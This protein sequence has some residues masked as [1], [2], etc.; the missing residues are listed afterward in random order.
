MTHLLRT[1]P[2]FFLITVAV[3]LQTVLLFYYNFNG[4][5]GQD[6]YEYLRI[7]R[8]ISLFYK[9]GIT[10]DYTV[11]PIIYPIV[12]SLVNIVIPDTMLAMQLVSML[13]FCIAIVFMWRILKLLY[14]D[15]HL[16]PIFILLFFLLS[17]YLLRFSLI[18]MSDIFCL[19]LWLITLY[20]SLQYENSNRIQHLLAAAM[21]AGFAILT[22]YPAAVMVLL[23]VWI[24]TK[25]ILRSKK[26]HY[27]FYVLVAALLCTLPDLIIRQRF[28]FWNIGD[29]G[30]TFSYDFFSNQFSVANL[31]KRDFYNIDGWQ[32]Y[33][34]PNIVFGLFAFIHPAFIFCGVLFLPFLFYKNNRSRYTLP[35]LIVII[36]YLLFIGCNPYQN[37]RYL[38][39][40]LPA[41]LFVYYLPFVN[42]INKINLSPRIQ[43]GA[44]IGVILV[45]MF[46]FTMSFRAIIQMNQT[47]KT[48][49]RYVGNLPALP[50]YTIGIDGALLAY[51]PNMEIINLYNTTINNEN[52]QS[53]YLLIQPEVIT[54]QFSGLLPETNYLFLQEQGKLVKTNNLPDGWELYRVD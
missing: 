22:R 21:F 27:F 37:N 48:I 52:K 2:L 19:S 30:P 14:K 6:S 47:E 41:V 4:Y 24:C 1:K 11:Y 35:L 29:T 26:Y 7:T 42:F 45:Q 50:V 31:F 49:A 36:L 33:A 38:M 28:I 44:T 17:P 5:F 13:S 54:N 12:C 39:F 25:T 34:T 15:I 23:P 18:A 9:T 43:T 40:V 3:I 51:N 53:G 8:N 32:H 46:L 10:P 20:F 16:A